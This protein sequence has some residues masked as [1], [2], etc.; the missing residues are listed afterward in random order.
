ME[1][2]EE[3]E[4]RLI[5]SSQ[6]G[7]APVCV[8]CTDL[9]CQERVEERRLTVARLVPSPAFFQIL[10]FPRCEGGRW[11]YGNGGTGTEMV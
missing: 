9:S 2:G 3:D 10:M 6:S 11:E 4:S 1:E 8:A 7:P 5:R